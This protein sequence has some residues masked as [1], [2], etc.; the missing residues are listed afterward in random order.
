MNTIRV[1]LIGAVS[2]A[3]TPAWGAD[4]D[5]PK[6]RLVGDPIQIAKLPN[7]AS[8][9]AYS[10]V[11]KT[12]FLVVDNPAVILELGL[13]G[14]PRRWID[15]KGFEDMEGIAHWKGNWFAV[16]EERRYALCLVAIGPRT[17]AVQ[18]SRMPSYPIETREPDNSGLEGVAIDAAGKKFY[19]VKEK[20]PR[21]LYV[22]PAPT[23]RKDEVRAKHPWSIDGER[24]GGVDDLS[25]MYFD[26]RSGHLLILSDESA[27][28]VEY[29][30]EG[31]E[32]A[33]LSLQAGSAG[34]SGRVPKAEGI[35]MDGE[36]RL[37]ICSEPNLLYIFAKPAEQ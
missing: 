27:A 7:N 21:K 18:R 37:Y 15:M 31:K 16:V 10:P 6:Y 24:Q 22:F 17:E 11:T 35:T 29:T 8:G 13:D 28:V 5:L 30:S 26:T 1:A 34:L 19:C 25:G 32:V 12:L 14:R 33:R 3:M 2:F 23:S 20:Y 9:L 4:V 36:G